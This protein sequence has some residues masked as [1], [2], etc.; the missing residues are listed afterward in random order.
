MTA[1]AI[2]RGFVD[3]PH[4]Q[5]HYRRAGEGSLTADGAPLLIIHASPGSS[6][7]QVRLIGDFAGVTRVL[8][9]DTPGNGD[10]DPLPCALAGE[11]PTIPDLAAAVNAF[12]D[13]LGVARVNVY[14]SHTGASIAAE[15]AILAP[16]KVN[17]LVLDGVSLM[18]GEELAEILEKYAHPFN[19]D[20][21]GAYLIRIFQFC[22]DQYMFFPW[23]NRTRAGRRDGG[24]PAPGDLHAWVLEVMKACQSYHL[25]YRAAF[26]WDAPA[27]MALITCPTLVIAAENDPLYDCSVDLTDSLRDGRFLRLPRLD[28]PDFAPTR[29][30]A[31]TAFFQEA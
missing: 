10:S 26:K 20:L 24:L 8:A 25:N 22:R 13:G 1:P 3:V 28:A 21:E 7:Q 31:M 2:R 5:T 11:E 14:G 6:R 16:E 4:G 17:R 30:A 12:L 15:L 29:A 19:P 18:V 27:R 23:Y 9:P